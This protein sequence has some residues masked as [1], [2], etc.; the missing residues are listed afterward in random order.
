MKLRKVKYV[1]AFSIFVSVAVEVIQYRIGR[2]FDIDDILL[3]IVGGVLGYYFYKWGSFILNDTKLSK[4]KEPLCNIATI[5]AAIIFIL[6]M[7]V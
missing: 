6:Y 1:V 5:L 7:G 3:N 2:V 4:I